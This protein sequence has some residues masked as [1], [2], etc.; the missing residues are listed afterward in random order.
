MSTFEH[1]AKYW[2]PDQM[3]FAVI[4]FSNML[5]TFAIDRVTRTWTN[6]IEPAWTWRVYSSAVQGLKVLLVMPF[7]SKFITLYGKP[8]DIKDLKILKNNSVTPESTRIEVK[9]HLKQIK[10]KKLLGLPGRNSS[11]RYF[12]PGA[13]LV[14]TCIK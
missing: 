14:T 10:Y 1:K 8:C 5:R 6:R 7:E 13:V 12:Y 2:M 4:W 11:E 3:Y 9:L